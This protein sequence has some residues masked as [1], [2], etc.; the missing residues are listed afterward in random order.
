[1]QKMCTF[2]DFLRPKHLYTGCKVLKWEL[3]RHLKK[4]HIDRDIFHLLCD[5]SGRTLGPVNS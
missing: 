5:G 2:Q 1:M 3:L 4:V